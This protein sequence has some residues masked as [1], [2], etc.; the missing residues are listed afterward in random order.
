MP[1]K[2]TI[3]ISDNVYDGLQRHVGKRGIGRFIDGVI[4]PKLADL[5]SVIVKADEPTGKDR[6][7]ADVAFELSYIAKA[8][9]EST[10]AKAPPE[11]RD[12]CDA[13]LDEGLPEDDWSDLMKEF[14]P[15]FDQAT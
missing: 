2:L 11:V 10:D 8:I 5:A 13:A 3:M 9:A 1:R 4:G 6:H 12:W 14:P 15:V 7:L